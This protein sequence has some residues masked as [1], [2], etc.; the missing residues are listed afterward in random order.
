MCKSLILVKV[1]RF[2]T[3]YANNAKSTAIDGIKNLF[4]LISPEPLILTF[5]KCDNGEAHVSSSCAM[6]T[7]GRMQVRV[8]T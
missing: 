5:K 4:G 3:N 6:E 1:V 7:Y 8:K 2:L